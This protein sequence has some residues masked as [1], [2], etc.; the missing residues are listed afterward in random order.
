MAA[1]QEFF[2]RFVVGAGGRPL[3]D[4]LLDGAIQDHHG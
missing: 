2:I 4:H 3:A 1:F